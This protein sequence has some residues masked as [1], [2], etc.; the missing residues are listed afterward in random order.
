VINSPVKSYPVKAVYEVV[1]PWKIPKLPSTR[2]KYRHVLDIV[3]F[4]HAFQYFKVTAERVFESWLWSEAG[5]LCGRSVSFVNMDLRMFP[6][7]FLAEKHN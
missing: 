7:E 1:W 6:P 2:V 4:K 5:I 3:D